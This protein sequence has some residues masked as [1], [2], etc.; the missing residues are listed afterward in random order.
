MNDTLESPVFFNGKSIGKSLRE[1]AVDLIQTESEEM[2]SRWFHSEGGTD[3]F[4][5]SDSAKNIIKQQLSFHGQ[6]VEWNCLEGVRTGFVI[7]SDLDNEVYESKKSDQKNSDE[8]C[9]SES[10][11]FDGKPMNKSVG[12][13]LEILHYLDVELGF[14]DQLIDN[15]KNPKDIKTLSATQFVDR[16]GLAIKNYQNKDHGFWNQLKARF[17]TIFSRK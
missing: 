14:R 4:T 16:F 13:A 9:K 15:F 10:I 12:L 11:Q 6:I 7:E 8:V 5:W 1:V 17:E 3:L 2:V